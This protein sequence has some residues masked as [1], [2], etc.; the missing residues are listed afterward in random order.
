[1]TAQ[2]TPAAVPVTV[3]TG[4]LG[5]GKTT[6]LRRILSEAHGQRIA[7]I[8]NEYGE[9]GIDHELLRNIAGAEQIIE[10]ANGCICCSVRGD[11]VRV[12]GDLRRER[13]RGTL[14]F[15]R[16]VIETT[17]LA[18]PGPVMRTLARHGPLHGGY[19]LDAVITVVDAKHGERTLD[20]VS[21]GAGAGAG[22]PI[23]S[24][25]PRPISCRKT[26]RTASRR[27]SPA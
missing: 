17:G 12:L 4:F 14:R 16:V 11:V 20:A 13:E 24:S 15:D 10:V 18:D 7:V 5:S 25:S 9:I 26:T 2:A 1:M 22:L 19:R 8:E 21:R 27:G 23:A 3:L 6:L